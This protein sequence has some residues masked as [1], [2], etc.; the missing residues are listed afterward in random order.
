MKIFSIVLLSLF[1]FTALGQVAFEYM[2]KGAI[3]TGHL[4][5]GNYLFNNVTTS[6]REI[7]TE[8]FIAEFSELK[9]QKNS[10]YTH[11]VGKY[12]SGATGRITD[13]KTTF[14]IRIRI[15][16]QSYECLM[17][18]ALLSDSFDY[19][20]YDDARYTCEVHTPF[21]T[22]KIILRDY[23][24]NKK[25]NGKQFYELGLAAVESRLTGEKKILILSEIIAK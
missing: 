1:T 4:S 18:S 7:Q 6:A 25:A 12:D 19:I 21:R 16:N 15:K 10:G 9:R 8:D 13:I 24:E 11:N 2:P 17:S 22:Y 23:S 14:N 5:S 3:R 20:G